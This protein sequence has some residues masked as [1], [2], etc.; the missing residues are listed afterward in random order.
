[1]KRSVIL[2]SMLLT[3]A[4]F[5]LYA[6][7]FIVDGVYYEYASE[8]DVDGGDVW[9]THAPYIDGYP[10]PNAY[11]GDI[12]IPEK[13]IY[14]GYEYKIIGLAQNAFYNSKVSSVEI[15]APIK[16]VSERAF[17]DCSELKKV[18][19]P[20]TI[21]FISLDAFRNC[22]SLEEVN[23]TDAVS[24]IGNAA[25][26][27]CNSLKSI[28]LSDKITH[29]I[30]SAFWG[31]S[32]LQ[33]IDLPTSLKVLGH[34]AFKDCSGLTGTLTIPENLTEMFYTCFNGC[35]NID[36]VEW[37]AVNCTSYGTITDGG[38][39]TDCSKIHKVVVGDNVESLPEN[40]GAYISNLKEVIIGK[41]VRK[42]GPHIFYG[43]KN[44]EKVYWNANHA[45]IT[46][47]LLDSKHFKYSSNNKIYSCPI[48]E[49][50]FG[51]GC[52]YIPS[53]ICSDLDKLNTVSLYNTEIIG[54]AAFINCSNLTKVNIPNTV[55]VIGENAFKG[56]SISSVAVP[57]SVQSIGYRAFGECKKLTSVSFNAPNCTV[58][59]PFELSDNIKT[60][61]F[62]NEVKTV[63]DSVC[64]GLYNLENLTFGNIVQNIG[65]NAFQ[66]CSKL[67]VLDL[68]GPILRI[69]EG[70]F[71]DCENINSVTVGSM[72]SSI[73]NYAFNGCNKMTELI[74][75]AATPPIIYSKTFS[76]YKANLRVP[77]D[78]ES[79]YKEALYWENFFSSGID[80]VENNKESVITENGVIKVVNSKEGGSAVVYNMNGQI[81]FS[82]N[83]QLLEKQ[84]FISGVYIVV[85]GDNKYK[86]VV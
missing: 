81:I 73:G 76:S 50:Y 56:T 48:T 34:N 35:S 8:F 75:F 38:P 57:Y 69:G 52:E 4:Q 2:L 70:C 25:F 82:G 31:C 74:I 18:I 11:V 61:T 46:G 62:G 10:D 40:F 32:S 67:E 14:R 30:N 45:Y 63:P 3:I 68:T 26:L 41:N 6:H 19:L 33:K 59:K 15:K 22:K 12:V 36:V 60:V 42:I 29:I 86:I 47:N 17:K 39:F 58:N 49:F 85:I 71:R 21:T 27:N 64:A 80:I 1:M 23:L 78:S 24:N 84:Y 83:C 54:M 77:L 66:G 44:L 79:A 5:N 51:E 72:V 53:F 65:K 7:D 55:T 13:V 37:N 28:Y 9:V 20:P 16:G 43:C